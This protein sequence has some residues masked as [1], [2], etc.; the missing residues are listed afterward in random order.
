MYTVRK[1]IRRFCKGKKV[2]VQ[3][4]QKGGGGDGKITKQEFNK[5][6]KKSVGIDDKDGILAE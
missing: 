5:Y 1:F 3:E 6:Y 2:F 4:F